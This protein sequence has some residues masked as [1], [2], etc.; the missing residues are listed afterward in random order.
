MSRF[1]Q[2]TSLSKVGSNLVDSKSLIEQRTR[3]LDARHSVYRKAHSEYIR[4]RESI[5]TKKV[6]KK[7]ITVFQKNKRAFDR[8]FLKTNGDVDT[9]AKTKA[10][11]RKSINRA[12]LNSV[13]EYKQYRALEK[14]YSRKCVVLRATEARS[15][16]HKL[17][18]NLGDKVITGNVDY[19][20]F[21]PTYPLYELDTWDPQNSITYNESFV[22]QTGGSLVHDIKFNHREDNWTLAG[23]PTPAANHCSLGINYQV[24]RTGFLRCS[25]IVQNVYNKITYSVSDLFGF[26]HGDLSFSLSLFIDIIRRPGE[27]PARFRREML[28][29]G[30]VSHGDS[31]SF[32]TSEIQNSTPYTISFTSPDAFQL[33]ESIQILAGSTL[34]IAS[35][36]DDMES[37]VIA[38]VWWQ[39]KKML[40]G[41]VWPAPV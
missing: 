33:G 28:H 5:L 40:V 21:T 2:R 4:Q 41:I 9:I 37:D 13:P 3:E 15:I 16:K 29:G 17:G 26:S 19:Q 25:A 24:P 38:V 8:S 27:E 31:M 35:V 23:I 22:E 7:S 14:A 34:W 20:E 36:L 11:T 10:E 32:W 1:P 39:L 12:L 18:I 6:V 30:L